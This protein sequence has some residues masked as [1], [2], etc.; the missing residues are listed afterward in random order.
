MFLTWNGSKN[1]LRSLFDSSKNEPHTRTTIL[2]SIGK[3]VHL[4]TTEL[5]QDQGVLRTKVYHDPATDEYELPDKFEYRTRA[6]QPS[7]LLHAALIRAVRCC[8]TE[9]D[10]Q[11]EMRHLRHCHILRGFSPEFV[12][13]CM[14]KFFVQFDVAEIHHGKVVMPYGKLRQRVL[15]HH[16]QQQV[17]LKMQRQAERTNVRRIRYP[18][19]WDANVVALVKST[20]VNILKDCIGCD[21]TIKDEDIEMVPRPDTPLTMNDYLVDKKPPYRLLILSDNEKNK[22]RTY[23]Y[24]HSFLLMF[25][26][27]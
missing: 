24:Y 10:F 23:S 27:I 16:Q 15:D 13:E 11:E 14:I 25:S 26:L 22:T 1:Q 21:T 9:A 5:R 2:S 3:R 17:A 6:R 12:R 7:K 19:S 8:S 4:L 18:K 20:Y